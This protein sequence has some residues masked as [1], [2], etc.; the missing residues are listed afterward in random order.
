MGQG[1][2]GPWS[3]QLSL[4]LAGPPSGH[5]SDQGSPAASTPGDPH[6]KVSVGKGDMLR[7]SFKPGV[8][9]S[10]GQLSSAVGATGDFFHHDVPRAA[11][12]NAQPQPPH[13]LPP[14]SR[15]N[16]RTH[17][18]CGSR[19]AVVRGQHLLL[20]RLTPQLPLPYHRPHNRLRVSLS[21]RASCRVRFGAGLC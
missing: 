7:P 1:T 17:G 15:L 3:L 21:F 12:A 18:R 8:P 2:R 20:Q 6:H 4:S 11:H 9:P 5:L 14:A 13:L 10:R 16:F 19:S